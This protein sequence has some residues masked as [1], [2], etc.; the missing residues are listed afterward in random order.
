MTEQEK[1]LR[2]LTEKAKELDSALKMAS[3]RMK[4]TRKNIK[5]CK[6]T[7]RQTNHMIGELNVRN[8]DHK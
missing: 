1:K 4:R 6:E 7:C 2:E 3:F 5:V 8:D